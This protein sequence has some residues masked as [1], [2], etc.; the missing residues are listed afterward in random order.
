MTEYEDRDDII[1]PY[2]DEV[3]EDSWEIQDSDS[4]YECPFCNMKFQLSVNHLISYS[5]K[6][7]PCEKLNK[8][9]EFEEKPKFAWIKKEEFNVFKNEWLPLPREKWKFMEELICKNCDEKIIIKIKESEF[10]KRYPY[11]YKDER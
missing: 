9:H 11:R 5:T 10:A 2:C 3:D 8:K 4:N 7:I 1:C 6:R